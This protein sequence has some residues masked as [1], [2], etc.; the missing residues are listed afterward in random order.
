MIIL[1]M[2]IDNYNYVLLSILFTLFLRHGFS[3]DSMIL[4][5]MIPIPKDKKK[6]LCS[7]SNYR[8]IAL[9]SIFSKILDWII[10]I[11]EEY[12]LCL[13]EL[14]FG[15]K[16]GLSTTQC[17]FSMLEVIDYYNVDKSSVCSLQL[18]A[19]K[20]LDR[21]NYCK[22]FAELLKR[23]ICPLLLKLLLFM[24]TSQS[25]RV[26]WGNTVSSEF[27]VSNGVKQGVVL[28]PIPFAIYT[29]GLLK[30]LEETGVGCHMGSRFAGALAY[31]DDITLLAPCKSALSILVSVCEKYASEFDILFNGSKSKLLFFK[32]R[33][34]N[35]MESG[36]M[37][38]GELVNI[39][40]NAV[41]LGHTISSSDRESISLTAKSSFWKSFNSFISNFGHTYSFIKCSLF[42]Q[43]CCS[44]YGSPLWNLNGPGVQS[45]CVDWRKS[46]RSLWRMV[47]HQGH[48]CISSA[49][50]ILDSALTS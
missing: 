1:F 34:S 37:V 2:V 46:L 25:L 13:S 49:L 44:F 31:A 20:A 32:G 26:K 24:Y 8:A 16:K 17:T 4:G 48:N 33:F 41:H 6:S 14:Q 29:D 5:T 28:S 3:P 47:S 39:S 10:L 21:V 18:D 11:K 23:N 27:T 36:I 45:L 38:N 22:L 19:T 43:F 35:G 12:S 30:R 15:F 42:K 7:S 40:D 9:S 50:T